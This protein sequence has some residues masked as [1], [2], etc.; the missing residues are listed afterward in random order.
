M[1]RW[2]LLLALLSLSSSCSHCSPSPSEASRTQRSSDAI[3]TN[4]YRKLLRQLSARQLL[5]DIMSQKQRNENR[6]Q[7]EKAQL[8]HKGDNVCTDQ[9]LTTPNNRLL[10][11]LQKH[12][13]SQG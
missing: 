1:P 2:V 5:L 12:R 4:N 13:N 9:K 3:F 11:L 10:T 7:A 8:G 6:E